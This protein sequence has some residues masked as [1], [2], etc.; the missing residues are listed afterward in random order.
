MYDDKFFKDVV[1]KTKWKPNADFYEESFSLFIELTMVD[2]GWYYQSK[3]TDKWKGNLTEGCF[4]YIWNNFKSKEYRAGLVELC[5]K[6]KDKSDWSF[7][8][9]KELY[10]KIPIDFD[11][12]SNRLRVKY[13]QCMFSDY[14][15][16]SE[17]TKS[18]IANQTEIE[19]VWSNAGL[20]KSKRVSF[21]NFMWESITRGK[22]SIDKRLGILKNSVNNNV[23]SEKILNHC[24]KRGTKRMKRLAVELLGDSLYTSRRYSVNSIGEEDEE[25]KFLEEKMLLFATTDDAAVVETL[26]EHLSAENLPWV[27]PSASNFPWLLRKINRKIERSGRFFKIS[28][29]NRSSK[30]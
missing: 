24:A 30:K 12:D 23:Y 1:F 27:M 15:Y 29:I 13:V 4:K 14:D 20:Y 10:D 18:R 28:C 7:N 22:G 19:S 9:L 5:V 16:L 17:V 26:V 6:Q 2:H 8:I 3:K 21:Y 11:L 25:S